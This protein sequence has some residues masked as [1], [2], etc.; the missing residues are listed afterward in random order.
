MKISKHDYSKLAEQSAPKS[1]I[2]KDCLLAFLVGGT[3]C[4]IGQVLLESY[5]KL[6]IRLEDAKTLVSVSLVFLAAVLT[7]FGVFDKIAKYAG[8]GTLVPITGFANAVVSPAIEYK[9]EGYVLGVGAKIFTIA[10]PVI[11]YGT[12]ASVV[13]GVIYWIVQM[14]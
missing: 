6:P 12:V 13:Y 10:G 3:I 5:K 2:I 7:A 4:T 1:P 14:I 9:A 8:A 11:V